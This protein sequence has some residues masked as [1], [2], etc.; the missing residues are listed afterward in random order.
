MM[1]LARATELVL[2]EYNL[3]KFRKKWNICVALPVADT[4]SAKLGAAL[5]K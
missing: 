3:V 5:G 1:C 4:L 2:T